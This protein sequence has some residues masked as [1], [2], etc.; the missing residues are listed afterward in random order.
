MS[1]AQTGNVKW[2]DEKKG[3]GFIVPDKGGDDVFVHHSNIQMEGFRTLVDNQKVV[4]V[5]KQGARGIEA[6]EV[7]PFVPA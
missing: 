4:F 3:Y 6:T 2:F 1:N 5:P 7:S